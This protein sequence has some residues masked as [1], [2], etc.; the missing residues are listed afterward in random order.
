MQSS[1]TTPSGLPPLSAKRKRQVALCVGRFA[2]RFVSALHAFCLRGG[3]N[4]KRIGDWAVVTG[5]TDGIGEA[6]AFEFAKRGL[7]VLLLSR[8][9]AKLVATEVS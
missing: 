4:L 6:M 7:N 1:P 9:E 2:L 8:T 3:K 5:A